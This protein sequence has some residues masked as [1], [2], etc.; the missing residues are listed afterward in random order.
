MFQW[1]QKILVIL[2]WTLVL[3]HNVFPHHHHDDDVVI[4]HH[5]DHDDDD[6]HDH[7]LFTFGQLDEVFIPGKIEATIFS[8]FIPSLFMHFVKELSLALH[9]C[10][11]KTE[12]SLKYE[13]PPPSVYQY[14]HTLR[15]PPA[16]I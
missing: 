16:I 11:K 7:N 4:E 13:F 5:D 6:D 12:Y 14:T 3:G 2:A 15:G 1:L 9:V 10:S 8:D